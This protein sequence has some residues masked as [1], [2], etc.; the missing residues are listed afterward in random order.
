MKVV[1][2]PV[3]S[4]AWRAPAADLWRKTLSQIP[5]A[6]GKLVYLASLRDEDSGR[7]GHETLDRMI[8]LEE[9]DRTL[10]Q[11]HQQVFSQWIASSLEDQKND[12]DRYICEVGG[13]VQSLWQYRNVV[14]PMARDVEKQ[15]YFT[16]FETL[17][18]LLQFEHESCD[19]SPASS[20]LR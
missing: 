17:L 6:F 8:G 4:A 7:Y 20:P 12:L 11:S 1:D 14:P 16:D 18:G 13:R 3:K 5:T 9:A 10:C 19:A 2:F 15:L